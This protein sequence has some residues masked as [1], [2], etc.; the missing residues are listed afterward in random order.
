MM[1]EEKEEEE[2]DEVVNC[3]ARL[4]ENIGRDGIY[5]VSNQTKGV[6]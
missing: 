3:V 1:V 4:I 5:H 2:E 6:L